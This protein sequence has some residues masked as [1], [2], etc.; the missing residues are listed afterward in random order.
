VKKLPAIRTACCKL[1]RML[2]NKNTETLST[3]IVLLSSFLASSLLSVQFSFVSYF[4]ST[5]F[6][7]YLTQ[8]A[9]SCLSSE[10][11]C[12][13]AGLVW[14]QFTY[15]L[16]GNWTSCLFKRTFR[17]VVSLCARICQDIGVLSNHPI[18]A[19]H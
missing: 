16:K 18:A 13:E 6:L 14:T 7:L 19:G 2:F 1:D 12:P 5:Q 8:Y 4:M 17:E 3:S 9:T 11:C 10:C 15:R